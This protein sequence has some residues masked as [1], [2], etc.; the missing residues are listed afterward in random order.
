MYQRTY[1]LPLDVRQAAIALLQIKLADAL[2]LGGQI[3]TAHWNV[4]GRDF[5]SLHQ[6]F[7]KLYGE[8][9][10]FAD[11]IAERIMALGGAADGRVLTTQSLTTLSPYPS[12]VQSGTAH[13]QAVAGVLGEFARS[14]RTDIDA[15]AALGEAD[16]ADLLTEVSRSIDK[17]LW[18]VSSHL[19]GA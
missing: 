9:G 19:A 6:L 7:D 4:T 15:A 2:D 3:K 14:V 1:D 13:L 12:D 10:E 8:I 11:V 5:F 17:S 18:I 16:T